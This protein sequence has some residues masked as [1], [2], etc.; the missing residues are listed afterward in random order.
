M[1]PF[2]TIVAAVDFSDTSR[3]VVQAALSLAR[4]VTAMS[5]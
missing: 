2:R 5:A 3:D 1:E 4:D